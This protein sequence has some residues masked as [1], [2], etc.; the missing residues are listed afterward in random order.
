MSGLRESGVCLPYCPPESCSPVPD[1]R[2]RIRRGAPHPVL[3]D[4][5]PASCLCEL[6]KRRGLPRRLV[7]ALSRSFRRSTAMARQRWKSICGNVAHA[8]SN[9][10]SPSG[11]CLQF[12]A[13]RTPESNGT[14]TMD[15]GTGTQELN[16]LNFGAGD[17]ALQ[18][19]A[20]QGRLKARSTRRTLLI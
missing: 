5:G 15:H 2:I 14:F 18:I 1:S 17:F 11:H 4:L 20:F 12:K 9:G 16:S 3:G 19:D 13:S 8:D 6:G 7:P 10:R